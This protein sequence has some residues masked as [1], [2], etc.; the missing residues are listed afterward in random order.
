M[1]LITRREVIKKGSRLL[2]GAATCTFFHSIPAGC[3]KPEPVSRVAAQLMRT[4]RDADLGDIRLQV[5]YDNVPH[6]DGLRTDWGF[7]C[8]VEGIGK[9]LLFD[10][11]RYDDIF[12][13]NLSKMG[14]DPHQIDALFLSHDHPDHTG[15]SLRLLDQRRQLDVYLVDAFPS[16]FK[17]TLQKQGAAVIE[18]QS[19]CQVAPCCLSTG[20]MTSWVKNEQALIILTDKGLIIITGC[21]HP[22]VVEIVEKTKLLTGMDVLLVAG[23]FHLLMDNASSIRK[24]ALRLKELGVRFVA[25]SHCTGSQA[26]KLLA[27][28]YESRFIH[29]G[30]GRTINGGDLG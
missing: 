23:G 20:E 13:R 17:S 5:V 8:L 26:R 9:T 24:K 15:G 29:S 18:T 16:G 6:S 25:P 4:T 30:V 12:M 1:K 11:G 19:P 3:S 21:A 22:G 2:V 28:V 7:A 14:I 27:E 10:A